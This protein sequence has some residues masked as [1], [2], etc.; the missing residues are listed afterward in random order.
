[1]NSLPLAFVG[2]QV[3]SPDRGRTT[4]RRAR[5]EATQPWYCDDNARSP[6]R[7]GQEARAY[8]LPS[9]EALH[10]SCTACHAP[11][12]LEYFWRLYQG[13]VAP[14]LALR[15]VVL[16]LSGLLKNRFD[17]VFPQIGKSAGMKFSLSPRVL[18]VIAAVLLLQG[19]PASARDF[20]LESAVRYAREHNPD[21]TAARFRIQ[22]A[23]GRHIDSGRLM[24]PELQ[25]GMSRMPGT[26][27][28]S[29]GVALMQKFPL[30]SRLRLEKS[31][32]RAQLA[33][34]E[35]EVKD[36]ERMLG[37]DVRALAIK[38]LYT[39]SVR[40]LTDR[41]IA[42]SRDL[43]EIATGMAR[44]GE[45]TAAEIARMELEA[46]E[47]K[48][49]NL[50][51]DTEVASMTG[52]LRP[53]M[54]LPPNEPL[55]FT[56][57]LMNS[58]SLPVA[59]PDLHDRADYRAAGHMEAAARHGV[60]LEKA[61]KYEDISVGA[62]AQADRVMDLPYGV[63]SRNMVGFQVSIPLPLWNRNEGKIHEAHAMADRAAHEKAAI[64]AHIQGD[65]ATACATMAAF[66][67]V[68]HETM[69]VLIPKAGEIEDRVREDYRQGH[70]KLEDLLRARDKRLQLEHEYLDAQRDYY[71]AR[72]QWLAIAGK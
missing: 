69:D 71:L 33:A 18:Q 4:K 2:S 41:Q 23:R 25:I 16:P 68:A 54:G 56:G 26:S 6:D 8:S 47:L 59:A 21:L 5:S 58:V 53:M 39:E 36:R 11:S 30:T 24:N 64:A 15:F 45:G 51:L 66:S 9:S 46:A 62:M 65:A 50:K 63:Q 17:D 13:C 49:N 32:T 52:M 31:V 3:R 55:H 38:L 43:A 72:A 28:G 22:E 42:N 48:L 61:K 70:A 35:E 44:A 19:A 60:D 7:A 27:A 37:G 57:G 34:A 20:T 12:G 40:S 67:K 14:L 10:Q 29:V 1:M